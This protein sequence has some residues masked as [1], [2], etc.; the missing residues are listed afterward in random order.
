VLRRRSFSYHPAYYRAFARM[1]RKVRKEDFAYASSYSARDEVS[2]L[3]AAECYGLAQKFAEEGKQTL[4]LQYVKLAA[5]LLGMS[6]R[7]KKLLDLDEIKKTL[8]R[9]NAQ[10]VSQ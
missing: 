8:A 4:S 5:K 7:P 3:L 10:K 6:L 9:V 2:R 1:T